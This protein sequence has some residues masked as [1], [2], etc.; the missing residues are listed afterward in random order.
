MPLIE[1]VS[2]ML[3]L[4]MALVCCISARL[5][6]LLIIGTTRPWPAW[7]STRVWTASFRFGD[8]AEGPLSAWL[9]KPGRTSPLRTGDGL[10]APVRTGRSAFWWTPPFRSGDEE[11]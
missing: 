6:G 1:Q 11:E 10:E 2:K 4:T 8:T 3:G 9:G 5:R 7:L